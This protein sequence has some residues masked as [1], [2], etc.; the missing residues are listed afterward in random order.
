MVDERSAAAL[1]ESVKIDPL[2]RLRPLDFRGAIYALYHKLLS[3]WLTAPERHRAVYTA[4]PRGGHTALAGWLLGHYRCGRA[5]WPGYLVRHLPAHLRRS[6]R[7][8]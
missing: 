4:S 2:L 3:D 6:A 7:L 8:G 5:R 1:R